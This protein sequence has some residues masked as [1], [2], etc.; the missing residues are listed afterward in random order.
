MFEFFGSKAVLWETTKSVTEFC[1][2]VQKKAIAA[3][4]KV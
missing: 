2:S 1:Q 3:L 4:L